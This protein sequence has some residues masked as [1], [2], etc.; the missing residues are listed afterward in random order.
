MTDLLISSSCTRKWVTY[1]QHRVSAV[2]IIAICITR[3]G[4][5]LH[6]TKYGQN[7]HFTLCYLPNSSPFF[8]NITKPYK[9][10]QAVG[11]HSFLCDHQGVWKSRKLCNVFLIGYLDS[12]VFNLLIWFRIHQLIILVLWAP[13]AV[14]ATRQSVNS[15]RALS[16]RPTVTCFGNSQENLEAMGNTVRPII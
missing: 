3:H 4:N 10:A 7:F 15:R 12:G 16:R 11:Y 6:N 8:I 14:R 5:G 2:V 9:M 13:H 1:H